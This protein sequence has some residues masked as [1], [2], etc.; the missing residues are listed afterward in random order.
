VLLWILFLLFV[1]SASAA[2]AP[3]KD[4]KRFHQ[5]I[6]TTYQ[7]LPQNTVLSILESHDGYLWF[8]T[9]LGLV[10][11][12]GLR[13]TVFDKS[14]TPELK[15][16]IITALLEDRAQNLWIGTATGGLLKYRDRKFTAFTVTDGL[17]SDSVNCLLQDSSGDLW[18]GT[19]GGVSRLR[20]GRFTV[21]NTRGGLRMTMSPRWPKD[22]I[23]ASGSA[24]TAAGLTSTT[25]SLL[26]T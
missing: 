18:I 12:D 2:L 19:N 21:C 9:E 16:N 11:F 24:R 3:A 23:R 7:G 20:A 13:F 8:G 10:R 25:I 26:F 14:N 22:P 15:N 5:D 1:D 6:W 4:I 17:S